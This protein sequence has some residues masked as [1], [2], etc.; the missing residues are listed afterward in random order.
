MCS[1]VFEKQ[2]KQST[3]SEICGKTFANHKGGKDHAIKLPQNAPE[4]TTTLFLSRFFRPR[5]L[6]A[7]WFSHFSQRDAPNLAQPD[8]DGTHQLPSLSNQHFEFTHEW[9]GFTF[10][11]YQFT[12]GAPL[13]ELACY[14]LWLQHQPSGEFQKFY[15]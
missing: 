11:C 1:S 2:A 15:L 8:I 3:A 9:P 5:A 7:S 14:G 12:H 6:V 10:F 13:H 4:L